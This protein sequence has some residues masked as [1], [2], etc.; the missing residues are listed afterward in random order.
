MSTNKIKQSIKIA[1]IFAK[2]KNQAFISEAGNL[3]KAQNEVE[4]IADLIFAKKTLLEKANSSLDNQSDILITH[5][6]CHAFLSSNE[7]ELR[8]LTLAHQEANNKVVKS[9]AKLASLRKQRE[10]YQTQVDNKQ[11]ELNTQNLKSLEIELNDA[12]SMR[13]NTQEQN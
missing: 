9:K 8:E 3:A 11:S 4:A 2:V 10:N 6:V 5:N 1:E 13:Y 12:F 7:Q